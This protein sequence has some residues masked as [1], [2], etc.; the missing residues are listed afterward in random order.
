MRAGPT[1]PWAFHPDD[2]K[3]KVKVKVK[4]GMKSVGY[5]PLYQLCCSGQSASSSLNVIS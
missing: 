3:V 5:P 2:V 1:G 4:T